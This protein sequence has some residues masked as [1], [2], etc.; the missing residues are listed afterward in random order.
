MTKKWQIIVGIITKKAAKLLQDIQVHQGF[1]KIDYVAIFPKSEDEY[2]EFMSN[3]KKV[4]DPIRIVPTGTVFQLRKPLVTPQGR[5]PLVRIRIY[6]P[7]KTQMGYIDYQI[8]NYQTFREKYLSLNT[9]I[10]THN[11]EGVE[12][13]M[14]ENKDIIIYFP[15]V[16]IQLSCSV[17]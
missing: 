6:D 9:V 17:S 1:G 3:L 13:L 2:N 10:I 12:M 11:A 14:A 8:D 15:E 4:G 5:I 7:L 16:P